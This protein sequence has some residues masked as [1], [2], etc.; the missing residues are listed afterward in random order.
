MLTLSSSSRPFFR[1]VK[2]GQFFSI[3]N[4]D[5]IKSDVCFSIEDILLTL[6]QAIYGI[7]IEV[8]AGAEYGALHFFSQNRTEKK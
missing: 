7:R 2:T 6:C 8:G 1:H 4:L 3:F 5:V